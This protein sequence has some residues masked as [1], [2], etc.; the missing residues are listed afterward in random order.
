M[1]WQESQKFLEVNCLGSEIL[2]LSND[3]TYRKAK[4]GMYIL[5]KVTKK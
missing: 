3:Y 5:L 1:A 2:W 4:A